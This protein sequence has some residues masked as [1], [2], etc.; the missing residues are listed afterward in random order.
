MTGKGR[1]GLWVFFLLGLLP[2]VAFAAEPA[3]VVPLDINKEALG[4]GFKEETWDRDAPVDIQSDEMSVNFQQREI[5]FLGNVLVT[6]ADFSLTADKVT[7]LFGEQAE[8]IRE[9]VAVGNVEVHKGEKAAWGD[10]AVYDRAKATIR[11][12]GSP[13]LQQGRDFIQGKEILFYLE[14]DRMHVEGTVK[15]RFLPQQQPAPD[16]GK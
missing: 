12:S 6:Q 5:V 7:A 2:V 14:D 15:V 8:D 9:I 16:K 11:L 3:G 1:S 4:E 10:R 13:R